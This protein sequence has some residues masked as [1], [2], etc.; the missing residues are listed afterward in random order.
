MMLRRLLVAILATSSVAVAVPCVAQTERGTISGVV[1]DTTGAAVPGVAVKVINTATN[2]A[3]NVV[4]SGSGT[5][6]AVN[7][8]P[9]VYRVEATLTG[10]QTSNVTGI[11]LPAGGTVRVDVTLNLGAV[12]ESLDVVAGVTTL[13]T[14]D[15]R[16]STGVSNKLIDE[17]PLVVGG[18]MRSPYDLS[19]RC[20]RHRTGALARRRSGTRIRRDTGRHLCQ[21][22]PEPRHHRNRAAGAVARIHHRVQR[23]NQRLQAGIRPGGGRHRHVC[24]EIRHQQAAGFGVWVLPPRRAGQKGIL[25]AEQGDL[26]AERFRRIA[27]RPGAAG[28]MYNGRDRTFFF[29]TYEG[30]FNRQGSNSSF[31][32]VPTPEMWNGDFSNWVNASGQRIIIYDP[33][34]RGRIRTAPASSAIRSRTTGFRRTASAPSQSST[35]RLGGPCSCRTGRAWCRG[36]WDTSTTTTCSEGKSSTETTHKFSFKVDHVFSNAHR[37]SYLFNRTNNDRF[38]ARAARPDCPN[39]SADF[40]RPPSTRTC[41][42]RAGTGLARGW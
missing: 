14:E 19:R 29:A 42:V 33:A 38:P 21:H 41:I 3:A 40:R 27:G 28:K 24:V 15:A 26:Q 1:R 11:T 36:R 6:S 18:A 25:R 34:P 39:R 7:L 4:S 10:F 20:P 23:R 8:Q 17:L 31:P 12:T 13:Q 37:V 32:S 16:V 9:G 2:V 5:Y 22:Q 30:F 35:S